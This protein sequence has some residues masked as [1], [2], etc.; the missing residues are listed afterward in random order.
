MPSISWCLTLNYHLF[1]FCPPWFSSV[2]PT[3]NNHPVITQ[4]SHNFVLFVPSLVTTERLPPYFTWNLSIL[5][6]L[7]SLMT[8]T[9]AHLSPLWN[10]LQSTPGLYY[11]FHTISVVVTQLIKKYLYFMKPEGPSPYSQALASGTLTPKLSAVHELVNFQ[12]SFIS[13]MSRILNW[14]SSLFIWIKFQKLM[15]ITIQSLKTS[16]D[17][18][19]FYRTNQISLRGISCNFI[20]NFY[21]ASATASH[22]LY[23][24]LFLVHF[25]SYISYLF[26]YCVFKSSL[27]LSFYPSSL[28][29]PSV[30]HS[31]LP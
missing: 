6:W 12:N 26:V 17:P 8:L 10:V 20:T 29:F 31:L 18:F 25:V 30:F 16:P 7:T 11:A 19:E 21:E 13:C 27:T 2:F 1:S 5:A 24:T 9:A 28:N 3:V 14:S 22:K 15:S 4:I 23:I